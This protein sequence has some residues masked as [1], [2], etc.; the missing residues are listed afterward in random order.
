MNGKGS[1][2]WETPAAAATPAAGSG[3][4]EQSEV[5]SFVAGNGA[6]FSDRL[7]SSFC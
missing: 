2:G 7:A 3:S 1:R 6:M 4:A 5:E